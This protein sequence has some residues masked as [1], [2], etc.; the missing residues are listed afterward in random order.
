M[1][2]TT[3]Y[4]GATV[5]KVTPDKSGRPRNI[6]TTS[7]RGTLVDLAYT[8]GYGT[9]SATDGD[10]I[11]T[12]ADGVAGTRT[13]YSYDGAG[14][15]SYAAEN[16]GTTL[17]QAWQYCYDLVGNLTSQGT[18]AGCPRGTAYTINDAQQMTGKS[19]S[20]G[21]WSHGKTGNETAADSNPDSTHTAETWSDHAQRPRSPSMPRPVP[22][23][24]PQ[25]TR[26]NASASATRI[27]TT[28]PPAWPASPPAA[29]TWDSTGSPGAP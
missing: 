1:R 22:V 11:R 29:S 19:T 10:K 9:D 4:P 25:P 13:T 3:T 2:T 7:P 15:F 18:S 17:N 24:T 26:A 8:Y 28:G 23:S 12:K 5:Q 21:T 27:S 6:K 14:R 20:T 16:K